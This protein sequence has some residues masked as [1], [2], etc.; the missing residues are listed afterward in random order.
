MRSEQTYR[1]ATAAAVAASCVMLVFGVTYRVMAARLTAVTSTTALDKDVLA[2]LPLQLGHWSGRDV[3][4][5][6]VLAERTDADAHINRQ[7]TSRDGRESLHLYVAC[8]TSTWKMTY[9]RPEIC[10][11]GAGWELAERRTT[12]LALGK[13]EVLPCTFFRFVR[14]GLEAEEVIILYYVIA[15]GRYYSDFSLLDSRTRG[16]FSPLAYVAQV[17]IIA[18]SGGAAVRSV[19]ERLSDFALTSVEPLN[20]LLER[21]ERR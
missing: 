10:Y 6:G 2:G 3:A 19:E 4:L 7:Y 12:S 5:D 13:G 15:D 14:H 18:S 1:R 16:V 21:I 20:E 11:P 9:H 8:G 17:Q